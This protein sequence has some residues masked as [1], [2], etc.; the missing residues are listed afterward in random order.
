MQAA[1]R[2]RYP[3]VKLAFTAGWQGI[4]PQHTF[5]HNAGASYDGLVSMPIFDGGLISAHID[6]AR[7]KVAAAQAQVRQVELELR[8][9]LAD[10]EL[11]YRQARDQLAMLSDRGAHGTGQLRADLDAL[12][13]RRQ[14]HAARGARRLPAGRAIAPRAPDQTFATRQAAAQ[15]ALVLGLDQ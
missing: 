2:E 14:R 11:R 10:A 3:T 15:G 13:R 5:T 6:E 12:S 7:A 1:E 8:K 9:Q 4:N